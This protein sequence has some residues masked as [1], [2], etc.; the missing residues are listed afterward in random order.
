MRGLA[1][2]SVVLR[3]VLPILILL[4]SF[5]SHSLP[6]APAQ[7]PQQADR[8]YRVSV[9][10]VQ[11]DIMVFDRRGRFVDNLKQDQFELRVDGKVQPLSFV[12]LV[13]SGSAKD[14]ETWTQAEAGTDVILPKPAVPGSGL[15]RTLLFFVDDWHLS[16][17]S[18]L[19]L[20]GALSNLIRSSI[21]PD[22]RAAII[23]ATSQAGSAHQLTSDKAA[24]RASLDQLVFR[25]ATVEDLE[26]PPMSEAQAVLLEQGDQDVLNYF[27]TAMFGKNEEDVKRDPRSAMSAEA[28][29]VL[30][31]MGEARKDILRRA[32]GLAQASAAITERTLAGLRDA[33]RAMASLPG[34]KI[35]FLL[36]DG[37]VLQ[38][39][40]SDVASRIGELTTAASRAGIVI[41]TLDARGLVVGLPDA[42][43]QRAGDSSGAL[44][45]SGLNEVAAPLDGLNALASDTGGRLLKNTNALD[46]AIDTA[47]AE[48]SRYYL[49]GWSF[50]SAGGQPGKLQSIRVAIKGRSD[51]SV[52]VR[53]ASLDLSQLAARK[54]KSAGTPS[55]AAPGPVPPPVS[56]VSSA[57]ETYA[58]A[59]TVIDFDVEELRRYY[60]VEVS[61]LELAADQS[62]LQAHLAKVGR[63]VD[64]FFRA[65][66]NTASKEE[67]VREKVGAD[68]RVLESARQTFH[69]SAFHNKS[70]IWE[71]VRTDTRGGPIQYDPMREPSFMNSGFVTI[72]S[73]FRP[74]HQ[75]ACRFRYLGRQIEEPRALVIA[76][77]QRPGMADILGLFQAPGMASPTLT[78]YQGLA[79]VDPESFQIIRMRT[80]LLAPRPDVLLSRQTT[81]VRFGPVRFSST[82][83]VFWLPSEVVVETLWNGQ[84]FR[85]RHR[86]SDYAVFLIETQ[87]KFAPPVVKKTALMI[88]IR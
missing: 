33:L 46:I 36:S 76:F 21:E 53:Q 73:F 9:E 12:E 15:R 82:P 45:H 77:A 50:D 38:P 85:N 42:K 86:Y 48:T 54:S 52:R 68:R 79:W 84:T 7:P 13:T 80:D 87:E 10:V 14:V 44:A 78:L 61:E 41:Y 30:R 63:T 8:I 75:R 51:L 71:E 24:L 29:G 32:A 81:Q 69:Y 64:A 70:G 67:V 34:R 58:R 56:A 16:A 39:S 17:D 35:F 28:F 4:P 60:P 37:F 26:Y 83:Q 43:K 62:E 22:D 5:Q 59:R 49:L 23:T 20:R 1:H 6:Q 27:V 19:R 25:N 40:R 57:N 18:I 65:F 2:S 74:A 72:G 11:T 55:D 3:G 31:A 47:L 66:P 88:G